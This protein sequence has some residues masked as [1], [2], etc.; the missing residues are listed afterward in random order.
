MGFG[1]YR[2][3]F[4]VQLHVQCLGWQLDNRICEGSQELETKQ[5]KQHRKP[6]T[7]ESLSA[8]PKLF[9]LSKLWQADADVWEMRSQGFEDEVSGFG[10]SGLGF[11]GWGPGIGEWGQQS[12]KAFGCFGLKFPRFGSTKDLRLKNR[13]SEKPHTDAHN[14]GFSSFHCIAKRTT[15]RGARGR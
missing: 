12:S 3:R 7:L 5:P 8:D 11:L 4:R 6:R 15:R 9:E 10:A 13:S 1:I 14:H 2:L